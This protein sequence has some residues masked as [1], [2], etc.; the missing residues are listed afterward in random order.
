LICTH[1]LCVKWKKWLSYNLQVSKSL[2]LLINMTKRRSDL[3]SGPVN[4]QR[5][6]F[7][8]NL[9]KI[10]FQDSSSPGTEQN[11]ILI[12]KIIPIENGYRLTWF[13]T[14]TFIQKKKLRGMG[15]PCFFKEMKIQEISKVENGTVGNWNRSLSGDL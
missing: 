8:K 10:F 4:A 2:Q 1:P 3:N 6:I 9:K 12:L 11:Q 7:L 13:T 15:R 5:T 14:I